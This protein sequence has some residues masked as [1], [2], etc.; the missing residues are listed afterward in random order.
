MSS[1]SKYRQV[2]APIIPV[3]LCGGS[4]TRLWPL[5]RQLYPKPF[6][7]MSNG[8]TLFAN[9]LERVMDVPEMA[10][11]VIISNEEYR[12]YILEILEKLKMSAGIILEPAARNTAPALA[13]AAFAI[14]GDRD[15]LMLVMPSDHYFDNDETLRET[16]KK[17]IPLAEAGY[18][19]TFGVKPTRPEQGYGYIRQGEELQECGFAVHSFIEK[20]DAEAAL[21]MI[22]E[23]NYFWNSGIFLLRASV[24]LEELKKYSP[25][26]FS[27]CKKAWLQKQ[28]DE[29]FMRPAAAEFLK[30][31]E[32]SIDYAVMER[33]GRAA[34]LPLFCG[35]NDMGSWDSFFQAG[36]RDE[37]GNVCIGDVMAQDVENSYIHSHKRFVAAVGVKDLAIVESGDAILVL[38][39]GRTQEVK[40]IVNFLKENGRE[41]FRL[42]PVVFRPWGN[43]ERLAAGS[44]FQVKRIIVKP[45]RSLSLQMH[46][47]R[48]EH[49]IIVR[50][51]AEITIGEEKRLYTENQSAYIPLGQ[52][53]KLYNPG[54]I[55]LELIEV[56]SGAYLGEDDICRVEDAYGRV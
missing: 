44:R 14:Q 3:I 5:S 52:L 33:T 34:M 2:D 28:G 50:G 8:K 35:W 17:A 31:P 32:D 9:T 37:S 29:K 24:Y 27:A 26:I 30:S 42:H 21:N 19:V 6:V 41:E 43:Y 39:R 40:K 11:P 38:P 55:P 4:G 22:Q 45:C 51:T 13:L 48:S 10:D 56:Q 15:R 18:I 36:V 12:F 47:H 7:E 20:P 1:T 49:W 54:K 16:V 23:G 25:E 46:H 53:H